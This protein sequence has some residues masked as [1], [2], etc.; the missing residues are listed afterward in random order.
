MK[1]ESS[2]VILT[3]NAGPRFNDVLKGI[4]SQS[5]KKFEVIILDSQST[6]GTISIA[7]K[8]KTLIIPI[9]PKDFGHGKT[10]NLGARLA[11]GKYVLFL[12]HD[13]VP[14]NK[15]W[16]SNLIKPL[17]DKK[18][19]G[20]YSRQLPRENENEIEKFFYLSLYP[21]ERKIWK[22]SNYSEGDNIFSDVSSAIKRDLLLKVPFNNKIIVSEDYEWGKR[23]MNKGYSLAYA[24]DSQV[25]HSHSYSLKSLFKR[26]FDI[27]VSYKMIYPSN[28]SYQLIGKGY[29]IHLKAVKHLVNNH[30]AHLVPYCVIKDATKFIAI[31]IGKKSHLLP[32]RLNR[33][34]SNY[35]GYWK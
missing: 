34:F 5:Y 18:I 9:N 10:R 12:T 7:R 24:A 6:D 33:S 17:K 23:I 3:R 19:A 26:C 13:A 11:K 8:Y 4:F 22:S 29:K 21:K 2:I 32:K 1:I 27:G 14:A 35:G 25:V 16:L 20:S 15:E 28:K 31:N 30:S